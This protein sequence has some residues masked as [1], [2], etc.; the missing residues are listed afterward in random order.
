MKKQQAQQKKLVKDLEK[1]KNE[2]DKNQK[3]QELISRE[4]KV[5]CDMHLERMN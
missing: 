1:Q 2:L 5:N 3:M 4:K